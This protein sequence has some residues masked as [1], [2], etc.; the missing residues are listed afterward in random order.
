MTKAYGRVK[1]SILRCILSFHCFT[2]HFVNLILECVT[3]SSYYVL[4][5]V[6]THGHFTASRG[7]KARGSPIPGLVHHSI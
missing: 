5:N 7:D 6:S 4:L 3:T 2:P 1:W